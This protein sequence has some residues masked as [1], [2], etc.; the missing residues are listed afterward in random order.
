MHLVTRTTGTMNLHGAKAIQP[1]PR[2]EDLP[3]TYPKGRICSRRSCTQPLSVYNRGPE[4]HS[5]W[6][7]SLPAEER[8]MA[9]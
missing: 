1:S 3:R 5:C 7:Q 8:E 2:K 6:L 9:A 4:C